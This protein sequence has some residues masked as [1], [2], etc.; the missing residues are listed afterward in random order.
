[1]LFFRNQWVP[2]LE[3]NTAKTSETTRLTN[4]PNANATA[5]VNVQVRKYGNVAVAAET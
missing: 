4:I 5:T 3:V 2:S 1:M